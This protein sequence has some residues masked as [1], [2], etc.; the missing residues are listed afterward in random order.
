MKKRI[1]L[2][3]MASLMIISF[4]ALAIFATPNSSIS[5]NVYAN[6]TEK[7]KYIFYFIG[8]GLGSSQRQ[9]AEYYLQHEL[10]DKTTKLVMNTL[11]IAGINT[12]HS[13]NS[14]VTD[15]A[16]A[17]TALAT[18]NKTN[19]GMISQSPAGENYKTLIE[20][21][22]EKGLSTG[23][24]TTTRITH[25]T[26]AVFASHN[27]DR[28]DENG[29]AVDYLDSGV[30]Y[31]AGGG[32]RHFLPQNFVDSQKDVFGDT[33]KSKRKDNRNLFSEFAAKGYK[34]MYGSLGA[35]EFK[36]Y[37]PKAGQ[38]VLALFA[39]SH[40]PYTIDAMNQSELYVPT[41]AE[42]TS[43]GIDLLSYDKDGFFM[44]IEGGRIDHACHP[45]DVMGA[46]RD[47]IAFDN[48]VKEAYEFYEKHP[49]ETLII[50]VGDHETGGL[51]MGVN[52]DYFLNLDQLDG[53][54]ASFEK[55]A[56][57]GGYEPNSDRDAFL[58]LIAKEYGLTD[59]TEEENEKLMT[60]MDMVDSGVYDSGN[61][62]QY[63]EAQVAVTHILSER[64]GV[65]WTSFAHT[66]TQIPMSA[67]GVGAENFTGY[68]DN[69][70]IAKTLANI[71]GFDL[72]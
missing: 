17:G 42:M 70:E 1:T 13:A 60:A 63:N 38:K 68:K 61:A 6:Q 45:N 44:M 11:P 9:I 59:L 30:D 18:G 58:Q 49:D 22:E 5:K 8:D 16:A 72:D 66:G 31:F 26:P 39:Y 12:T 28:D 56:Y 34:T 64:A 10:N 40:M 69:T 32:L 65:Y 57:G 4:I 14:L 67:V 47:T 37:K 15:S 27:P 48:A 54:K 7:P 35:K 23:I 3:F 43:K 55:Y 62:Y 71:C 29:I 21:A 52:T 33:I 50:I 2:S 20:V 53:V 36:N 25:A 51:G 19:N 24:V 46:I 41:I